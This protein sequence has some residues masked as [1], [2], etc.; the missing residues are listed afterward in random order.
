MVV[1]NDI[2]GPSQK[3]EL[4]TMRENLKNAIVL[5]VH[6]KKINYY[7]KF[8]V[9]FIG[10]GF[11]HWGYELRENDFFKNIFASY[12]RK[13]CYQRKKKKSKNK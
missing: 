5:R 2:L 10:T 9:D 12:T 7:D 11:L 8:G 4:M 6:L 13:C 3:E 1:F